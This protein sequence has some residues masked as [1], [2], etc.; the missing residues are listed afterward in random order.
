MAQAVVLADASPIIILSQIGGLDWLAPLFGQVR[1]TQIVR[2][3][4]LPS[5]NRPGEAAISAAIAAG[6]LVVLDRDWP[7][8]LFPALDE[9]E[10][11]CIRA[12]L[13]L[14]AK[15]L[16]LM[17]ERPGS[18]VAKEQGLAVVGVAGLIGI[19]KKRGLTPSAAAMFER[20]L[21]TDFRLSQ[22]VIRGILAS[23]GE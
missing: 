23:V 9:G 19:A 5:G 20:L 17:D 21:Q 3:E 16:L 18:V 22:E 11:S 7:G 2:D 12:A 1:L 6:V 10:A 13:N 14:P 8:P 15:C 4:V